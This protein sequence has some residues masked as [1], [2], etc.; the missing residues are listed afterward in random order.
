M[1]LVFG[2]PGS[3]KSVQGQLLAARHDWRW[4]STG[5]LLRDAHDSEVMHMMQSGKSIDNRVV[6]RILIQALENAHNVERIVLD[7]FPRDIEQARWLIAALPDHDRSLKA[8]VHLQ[9]PY[10]EVVRRLKIRGRFDDHDETIR[11]RFFEYEGQ[12]DEMLGYFKDE[13]I[14]IFEISGMGDPEEIHHQIDAKLA[15]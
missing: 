8:V 9:V 12:V 3:G 5:Q 4:L 7:G 11:K 13:H 14:P 2:P 6:Y 1:I 15:V 10:E